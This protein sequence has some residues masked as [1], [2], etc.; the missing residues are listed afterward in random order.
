LRETHNKK[1]SV[2]VGE[3]WNSIITALENL[4]PSHWILTIT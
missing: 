4:I 3:I 1:L 2:V